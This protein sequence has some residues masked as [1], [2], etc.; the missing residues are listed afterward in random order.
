ME[1]FYEISFLALDIHSLMLGFL[2]TVLIGFGT[3]VTLGHSGNMMFANKLTKF[4]F[5]W[6][7]IVVL[8]RVLVSVV[9]SLGMNFMILF[10][11]SITFWLV[12]FIVWSWKFLKVL[13]H[14]KKLN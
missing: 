12:L 5:I 8:V 11:I 6:T 4:I 3:R 1:L 10:D 13:T 14:G 9:A 2:L 7:Q